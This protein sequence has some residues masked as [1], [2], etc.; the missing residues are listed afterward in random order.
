MPINRFRSQ[1]FLTLLL[2]WPIL[3]VQLSIGFR[4]KL[5]IIVTYFELLKPSKVMG[6]SKILENTN[7]WPRYFVQKY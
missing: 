7:R 2:A 1:I 6:S 5:M 3:G 4:H